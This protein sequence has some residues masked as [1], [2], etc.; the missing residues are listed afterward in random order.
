MR[1]LVIGGTQ[2][3]GPYVVR[4]LS[5][6]GHDV[7]V[8]HRGRT[9]ADLP[10]DVRH[11]H[12]ERERLPEFRP[13]FEDFAPDVVLDM[14]ALTE[15]DIRQTIDSVQ[16]VAK[17][18]VAISS[19]DV[20][21]AYGILT[22]FEV[23]AVEPTPLTEDSPVR[24]KLYLYRGM[25]NSRLPDVDNYDKILIERLVLGN[26][27]MP[28]TILR[29][30]MVYGP[31]DGQHRLWPYLKR[32]D[33]G[34]PAILLGEKAARRH[35]ARSYVENVA[36]AI[37]L[38]VTD[39]RAAGRVYNVAEPEPLDEQAWGALIAEEVGWNGKIVILP[40]ADLPG[41]LKEAGNL[42]QDLSADSRRIREELGFREEIARDDAVAR[43]IQWER[44][45]PPAHDPGRFDYAAEDATLAGR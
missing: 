2:F 19:M 21:H 26:P 3:I 45:S 32:M 23:G 36:T 8:F 43:T 37:A 6:D 41:H 30:P 42:D 15:Q 20:Y 7:T 38:A 16:G 4:R 35:F 10:Q 24:E 22:G 31:G 44:S 1:V 28:G 40:D 18:L 25:K 29:L 39:E 27:E 34:R 17:R 5:R 13:Q 33:D 9:E 14:R 12:G 11:I